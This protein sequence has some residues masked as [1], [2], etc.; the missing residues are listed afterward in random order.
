MQIVVTA[1]L[2]ESRALVEESLR[3]VDDYQHKQPD[4]PARLVDWLRR[5]DRKSVG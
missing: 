5:A 1:F 3:L 2:D 4:F